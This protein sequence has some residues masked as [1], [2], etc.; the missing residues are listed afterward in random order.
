MR[1]ADALRVQRGDMVAFVGAGG[2]TSALFRLAHELR[3]DG[4]RV[5]ATTTTR[6][7]RHEIEHVPHTIAVA[8][9]TNPTIIR[10]R[11]DEH[12]FIFLYSYADLNQGKVIG[13]PP[14]SLSRLVDAVN[15]DVLLIEADGARRLPLKAPRANEPVLPEDVTLVV[16]VAGNDAL[17]QPLDEAHVFNVERIIERYGFPEGEPLLPPWMAVILRDP[18]LGL[19]R[20]PDTARVVPLLNKVPLNGYER[21]RAR[22]VAQLV[23]RSTRVEAVAMGAVRSP[24]DPIHELQQRVGAIVLAAGQ[25]TRMGRSKPLLPWSDGQ[26]VIETIV[27]R[28]LM[29]R[30]S[31]IVVVTGFEGERVRQAL[32]HLPVEFVDNPD[33][34]AGEM[35]SS[36]HAGLA[37]LPDTTAGA[38]VVLGDQPTLNGRVVGQVLA[39]YAEGRGTIV[40]PVYRGQ[41]GH[42]VLFDRRYWPELL[43][44]EHGAPRDVIR[45]YPQ[46]LALV[47]V[48]TDSILIDI[49][50]PEQYRRARLLAGLR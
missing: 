43:T 7:A 47:E 1:L 3:Q 38:L 48:D 22:L 33:Y 42:P 27:R 37:A 5:I 30:L 9:G 2:K 39:A 16:P 40:A 4:W 35:I 36:V 45:R 49:D 15:S 8:S 18:E 14:D 32:A 11:L 10:Q 26:T 6:L 46:A 44:L 19:R 41:R 28:L 29:F 21:A 34:A 17:G 12:G 23:L 50:T 13:L 24:I 31:E 25:S 20:V